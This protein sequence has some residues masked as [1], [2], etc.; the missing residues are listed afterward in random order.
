[1]K[2]KTVL[3]IG[4]AG[5]IGINNA[6]Y[7]LSRKY[8]VI[9]ADNL[10][11]NGSALNL[12]WL[13]KKWG[14]SFEFIKLDITVDKDKLDVLVAKVDAVYHF[15]SQIAV[16]IS[17]LNPMHDFMVN[18]MGTLNVLESIRNSQNKPMLLFS[19]TNKV[20]GS[21]ENLGIK[22][23]GD[24]YRYESLQGINE[25]Q[26]LDFH[27]P[28][29]CSKGAADQYVR[30]YA[31]VFGLKTVVFRQSCIYGTHQFGVEDQGWVAWFAISAILD[32]PITIYGDGHQSRDV[33]FVDDL[34]EL[35]EMALRNISK[36]S[37]KTYNI[38]GGPI[39]TL[40]VLGT[41]G[42]LERIL[43][44]KIQASFSDWRVGDQKVFIS[45]VGLIAKDLG[46][47]PTTNIDDG[48]KK[49]VNWAKKTKVIFEKLHG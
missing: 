33:L 8:N 46:W 24:G 16:T 14:E 7:L 15:A 2:N 30:D 39:N 38:G 4:G 19:S 20:Y 47:R 5:F 42:R 3:I 37:G 35:Y 49:V 28:Y 29:G 43:G 27:S 45:D 36:L 17:V 44:K 10:S 34:C 12:E 32:R 26:L 31:R 18:A 9:L 1:M 21:M 22:P 6:D 25:I 40:S 11:R 13:R 23:T 41:I 48:L